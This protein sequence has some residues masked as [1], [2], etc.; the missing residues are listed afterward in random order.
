MSHTYKH[1]TGTW[2]VNQLPFL[3]S[4]MN[5]I[6]STSI[7]ICHMYRYSC[8]MSYTC[9]VLYRTSWNTCY[10]IP[11]ITGHHAFHIWTFIHTILHMDQNH[12]LAITSCSR[13]YHYTSHIWAINIHNT[14]LCIYTIQIQFIT[15]KH[16]S[17]I[18][19]CLYSELYPHIGAKNRYNSPHCH[20]QSQWSTFIDHGTFMSFVIHIHSNYTFINHDHIILSHIISINI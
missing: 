13:R 4:L 5:G 15:Y 8:T 6:Q 16:L 12:I 2:A 17:V 11:D 19:H 14:L 7:I 10:H 18:T 9:H 1:V 20:H 3:L